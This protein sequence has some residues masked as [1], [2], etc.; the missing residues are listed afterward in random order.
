MMDVQT[1]GTT[2]TGTA[3]TTDE[4]RAARE[5]DVR[6]QVRWFVTTNFY[7]ADA[8]SLTDGASLLDSGVIDST[9]VLEVV[10][11]I[12]S[13]LG[14][15]VDDAEMVPENLDSIASIAAYVVRKRG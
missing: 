11:F 15:Q 6:Q 13:E 1:V 5:A 3:A 8:A 10:A 2:A 9:G 12:E 7:V 14:V 4:Q